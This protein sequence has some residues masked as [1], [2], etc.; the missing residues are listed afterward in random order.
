MLKGGVSGPALVAGKAKQSLIIKALEHDGETKMPS[1]STKLSNEIIADFVKWIDM[2]APDPRAGKATAK[3]TIDIDA[4]RKFWSFQP[5]AS[6]APPQVKDTAWAR[7]AIDR[8]I[9]AK[10]E[11]K[12]LK[13]N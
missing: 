8:F 13:P 4:G 9:L 10:L 3:R 12:G 11:A 1:R 2:G 5:L 7:T 6:A